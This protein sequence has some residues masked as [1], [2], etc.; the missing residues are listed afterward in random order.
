MSAED[1]LIRHLTKS[2]DELAKSVLDVH[3]LTSRVHERLES[4]IQ[5]NASAFH[6]L[7]QSRE[8]HSGRIDE[9]A[10]QVASWKAQMGLAMKVATFVGAPGL[11]AIVALA[12]KALSK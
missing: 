1:E 2:N 10:A 7:R 3:V 5:A 8:E 11:V 4:L 6:E 9:T 12:V